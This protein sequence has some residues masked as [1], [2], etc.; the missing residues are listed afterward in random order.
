MVCMRDGHEHRIV[1]GA[2][3]AIGNFAEPVL[4]MPPP[5]VDS[6][7]R[8][9]PRVDA[10]LVHPPDE[11]VAPGDRTVLFPEAMQRISG[12]WLDSQW[13]VVIA[14]YQSGEPIHAIPL[15]QV[16]LREDEQEFVLWIPASASY[17]IAVFDQMG[18]LDS[19]SERSPDSVLVRAAR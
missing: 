6:G 10:I 2:V 12:R 4:L 7:L 9:V 19:I 14:A 3:A 13:P 15:D 16:M 5:D 8:N 18:A 17:E 1:A 11:S